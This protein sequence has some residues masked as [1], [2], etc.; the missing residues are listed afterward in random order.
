MSIK[1]KVDQIRVQSTADNQIKEVLIS[2][3]DS[4]ES[5]EKD[6][7][8]IKKAQKSGKQTKTNKSE[9]E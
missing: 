8:V 7:A 4:I 1:D 2:I 3:A 6:F 9:T 5:I